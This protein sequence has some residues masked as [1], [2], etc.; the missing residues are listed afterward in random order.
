MLVEYLKQRGVSQAKITEATGVPEPRPEDPF[1]TIPLSDLLKLWEFAVH[2]TGDPALALKLPAL[3]PKQMRHL[4]ALLASNAETLRDSILNWVKYAPL[5]CPTDRIELREEG[6]RAC[7]LYRNLSPEHENIW[8]PQFYSAVGTAQAIHCVSTGFRHL[9][10]HVL[11]SDPGYADEFKKA[12]ACD[13]M[14]F[15]SEE[16]MTVLSREMLDRPFVSR[17]PYL[18]E[19]LRSHADAAL[20]RIQETETIHGQVR[21]YLIRSMPNGPVSLEAAA[22]ELLIEPRTLHRRLQSEG[23]SYRDLL[24]DTRKNLAVQY[25]EQKIRVSEISRLLGYS[26]PSAF[27]RAFQRWFDAS[28]GSFRRSRESEKIG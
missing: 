6:D 7:V 26:E 3:S 15:N 27:Q 20:S 8:M 1:F 10:C 25:L 21:A 14:F 11:Y 17:D 2:T 13:R 24:D 16:S 22:R 19:V 4:V 9:E 18:G 28:P 23:T 12:T 5:V